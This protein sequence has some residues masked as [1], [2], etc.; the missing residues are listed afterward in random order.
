MGRST[1]DSASA[2]PYHPPASNRRPSSPSPSSQSSPNVASA[3]VTSAGVTSLEV[4]GP[5]RPSVIWCIAGLAAAV[6]TFAYV[7]SYAVDLPF[8]DEWEFVHLFEAIDTGDAGLAELLAFHNEHRI[9]IPRACAILL[10]WATQYDTVAQSLF[11]VLH[12]S[13]MLLYA[14][15][16]VRRSERLRFGLA[17]VWFV[18]VAWLLLSWRQ[19]ENLLWGFQIGLTM[20]LTFTFIAMFH[21]HVAVGRV[22]DPAVGGV[23]KRGRNRHFLGAILGATAASFSSA[24]GLLAWPAGLVLLLPCWRE[25]VSNRGAIVRLALSWLIV[26]GLVWGVYFIGYRTPVH[27]ASVTSALLEPARLLD[28]FVTLCGAWVAGSGEAAGDLGEV[29]GILVLLALTFAT[30]VLWRRRDLA[31]QGIWIG[32]GAF[33]LA[34]LA[35]IA[36]GRSGNGHLAYRAAYATYSLPVIAVLVTLLAAL[37]RL[38]ARAGAPADSSRPPAALRWFAVAGLVLLTVGAVQSYRVGLAI[39]QSEH[40]SRSMLVPM[41]VDYRNRADTELEALYGNAARVRAGADYLARRR[42]SVFAAEAAAPR[43]LAPAAYHWG[44]EL[45]FGFDG[46]ARPFLREG[47]SIDE[48]GFV[49]SAG[50]RARMRFEAPAH[51][52]PLRL[53]LTYAMTNVDAERAPTQRVQ[54]CAFGEVVGEFVAVDHDHVT[55]DLAVPPIAAGPFDLEFVF[56]DAFAPF[57]YGLRDERRQLGV[58]V[59][60]LT[61][62]SLE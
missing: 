1:H 27:H 47:W 31:R 44:D 4:R 20:P 54:V 56:P 16:A 6:S 49:W 14:Y 55:V 39:A 42:W 52:G 26:G 23:P 15:L 30:V 50:R 37:L 41:L 53:E 33:A 13:V 12:M 8:W 19:A 17:P 22:G 3:G 61:L 58:A 59:S 2:A 11:T 35:M 7:S 9:I 46:N 5:F 57:D 36:V 25:A 45:R 48:G 18:L 10:A 24:M 43:R 60:S 28:F 38:P 29:V 40:A 62:S 34:T 21:L 51:T 32:V